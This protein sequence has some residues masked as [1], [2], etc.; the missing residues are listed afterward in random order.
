V[1]VDSRED[2][3]V[4]LRRDGALRNAED[5]GD[6]A[7]IAE[8]DRDDVTGANARCGFGRGSIDA[9]AAFVAQR[10]G[11]RAPLDEAADLEKLV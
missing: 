4:F 3:D 5:L 6:Q 7:G 1:H 11:H 10:T 9:D 2:L 8:R